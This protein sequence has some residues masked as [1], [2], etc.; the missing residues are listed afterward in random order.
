MG[1]NLGMY[2]IQDSC[3]F[4]LPQVIRDF[5]QGNYDLMLLTNMNTLG[6]V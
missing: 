4:G 3:G 5:N 1:L 6:V 2:N